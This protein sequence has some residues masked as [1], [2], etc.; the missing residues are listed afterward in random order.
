M[1]AHVYSNNSSSSKY[2]TVEGEE[3][4]AEEGTVVGPGVG[5][6]VGGVEG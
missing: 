4:G 3:V 6:G 1:G 2:F 5:S